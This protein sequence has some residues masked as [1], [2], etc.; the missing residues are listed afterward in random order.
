MSRFRTHC[1]GHQSET[2]QKELFPL[3]PFIAIIAI[4]FFVFILC[5]LWTLL[6]AF[7]ILSQSVIILHWHCVRARSVSF[8]A[9]CVFAGATDA[10]SV[11]EDI[12]F[13]SNDSVHALHDLAEQREKVTTT[14]ISPK[15]QSPISDIL[16][17]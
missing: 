12:R 10:L 2:V 6:S 1:N 9:E 17:K 4:L 15:K 3:L 5:T 7:F 13:G 8:F 14:R 11:L 16:K